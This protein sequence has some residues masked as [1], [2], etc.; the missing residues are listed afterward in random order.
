MPTKHFHIGIRLPKAPSVQLFRITVD[1]DGECKIIHVHSRASL[2]STG[3]P[4]RTLNFAPTRTRNEV[5]RTYR[6]DSLHRTPLL[7]GKLKLTGDVINSAGPRK[8]WL[9]RNTYT[10]DDENMAETNEERITALGTILIRIVPVYLTDIERVRKYESL[11][12]LLPVLETK[13]KG[14]SHCLQRGDLSW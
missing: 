8:M 10:S 6:L 2:T 1:I 9:T 11:Q 4:V 5:F 14:A 7:F 12:P 13:K 3:T